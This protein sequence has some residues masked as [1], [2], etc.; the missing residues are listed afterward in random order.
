MLGG[1][2][3]EGENYISPALYVDVKEEDPLLQE[4]IFGPIL[5]FITVDSMEEAIKLVNKG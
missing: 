3:D 5:P 1:E 2:K 4:E